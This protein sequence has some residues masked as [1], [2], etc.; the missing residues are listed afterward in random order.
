MSAARVELILVA[1]IGAA[2][3]SGALPSPVKI[4]SANLVLG[5]SAVFLVQTLIRD[6]YL[7]YQQRKRGKSHDNVAGAAFCLET[8]VGI[9]GVITGAGWLLSGYSAVLEISEGVWAVLVVLTMLLCFLLRD[10]V[11]RW[12]PWA[13]LRDPGHI[14][15]IVRFR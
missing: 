7:L 12:R 10:Y 14:N 8:T 1:G 4:L 3:F 15:I 9:A 6:L 2:L 11:I 13:I 5:L